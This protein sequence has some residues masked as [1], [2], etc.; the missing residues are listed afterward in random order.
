MIFEELQSFAADMEGAKAPL[1]ERSED[2]FVRH[3]PGVP[4]GQRRPLDRELYE[5]RKSFLGQPAL[6]FLH[7]ACNVILRR[8]FQTEHY[9]SIFERLWTE[10]SAYMREVV[11]AKWLASACDTIMDCSPSEKERALAGIGAI[12]IK[13]VKLY[14]TEIYLGDGYKR[15]VAAENY[16]PKD[17]FDGMHTF[18]IGF[19]DVMINFRD[20]LARLTAETTPA[21]VVSQEVFNRLSYQ[22]DTAISRFRSCHTY[23]DTLW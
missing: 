21:S 7:V 5:W 2:E 15:P 18:N 19:G 14:E 8:G 22:Y 13:T 9:W 10:Q 6:L 4:V 23:P 17:M 20:R 3:N 11:N 1:P 16:V 12:M